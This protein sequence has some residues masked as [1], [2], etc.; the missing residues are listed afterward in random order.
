MLRSSLI[1]V[2]VACALTSAADARARHRSGFAPEC[3]VT[4]P[5]LGAETAF[6][7][8]TAGRERVAHRGASIGGLVPEIASKAREIA[9][10][11][12]SHVISGVRHTRIA[13]TRRWSLHT[14]GKAVD[15]AGNPSCIY[16]HLAGWPGGVS[17]DYGRVRHVHFSLDREGGREMGAR[18]AHGRA[19]F[20]AKRHRKRR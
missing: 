16:R 5:C 12:G 6:F 1:A 9:A 11:C 3:N 15:M 20:S 4:M 10:A 19:T 17:T 8:H 14:Q 7:S 13:G 18:F 2:A